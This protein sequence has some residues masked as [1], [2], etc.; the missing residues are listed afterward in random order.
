MKHKKIINII[1]TAEL[2]FTSACGTS[3]SAVS[4]AEKEEYSLELA[5]RYIDD[6]NYEEAIEV[7]TAL[8]EVEPNN[9]SLYM[10]RAEAYTH[11]EKY[12]EA[13]E[14]FTQVISI[15]NTEAEAYAKRGV[16]SYVTGEEESG[17]NDLQEVV[18]LTED[19]A[20]EDKE[21]LY[22]QVEKYVAIFDFIEEQTDYSG[23]YYAK[24][25]EFPNGAHL[26]IVHDETYTFTV[27]YFAEN[28]EIEI[29]P[30]RN[31]SAIWTIEPAIAG[32]EV[33]DWGIFFEDLY[34]P[35]AIEQKG[36][37]NRNLNE[38]ALGYNTHVTAIRTEDQV[39]ICDYEG[40]II[41]NASLPADDY[42]R[43]AFQTGYTWYTGTSEIKY[44]FLPSDA[45]H[46]GIVYNADFSVQST[47]Q[48]RYPAVDLMGNGNCAYQNGRFVSIQYVDFES[49]VSEVDYQAVVNE[50]N[51]DGTQTMCH[52]ID[53]SFIPVGTVVAGENENI[54]SMSDYIYG[55]NYLGLSFVNGYYS[56]YTQNDFYAENK[57]YAFIDAS[58]GSPITDFIYEDVKWFADGYAPVK[59]NG[60]WG[61]INESGNEVTDFIFEDASALYEGKT[62]VKVNGMYGILNLKSALEE[63]IP[64]TKETMLIRAVSELSERAYFGSDQALL[65]IKE[66][67]SALPENSTISELGIKNGDHLVLI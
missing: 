57:S 38:Q 58:T 45:Y 48:E 28:E 4:A 32:N 41:S 23:E 60:M 21:E 26:V 11:V 2:L 49:S 8:I 18:A 3:M 29:K 19:Y 64:V 13:S 42:G 46:P 30:I 47:D 5:Q 52:I 62:F 55:G 25:Y 66:Y 35:F 22:E 50:W 51:A 7:Y 37:P 34:L 59:K 61:F 20:E 54:I 63:E 27:E 53:D 65:C 15:D 16:L 9:T 14:D 44:M 12:P 56:A 67:N 10:G 6:G 33:Y 17:D 43:Y 1:V 39:L 36:Y 31:Q 24:I 40:N